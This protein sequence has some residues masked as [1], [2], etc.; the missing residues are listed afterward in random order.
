MTPSVSNSDISSTSPQPFGSIS[1]RSSSKSTT[2][3]TPQLI[4]AQGSRFFWPLSAIAPNHILVRDLRNH[5][6]MAGFSP[7]VAIVTS[8][9]PS[10]QSTLKLFHLGAWNALPHSLHFSS[11]QCSSLA[12]VALSQRFVSALAARGGQGLNRASTATHASQR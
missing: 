7:F 5:A 8:V 4:G 1:T 12:F 6:R 2:P 9:S 10:S 11:P 3:A